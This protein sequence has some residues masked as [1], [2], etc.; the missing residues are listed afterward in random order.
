[1][2]VSHN[3][4]SF[5]F[6]SMEQQ[7]SVNIAQGIRF[8]VCLEADKAVSKV[9]GTKK[10]LLLFCF[11]FC[12]FCEHQPVTAVC[13]RD[14]EPDISKGT[15][16]NIVSSCITAGIHMRLSLICQ[17]CILLKLDP[18]VWADLLTCT[19]LGSSSLF[20]R[21]GEATAAM[22]VAKSTKG[23][24]KSQC[25]VC[26]FCSTVETCRAHDRLCGRGPTP[27]VSRKGLLYLKHNNSY[28]LVIRYTNRILMNVKFSF[29]HI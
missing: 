13:H 20:K 5:A 26:P 15:H 23:P 2:K 27:S 22:T 21:E 28:M 29:Y 19:H 18:S 16:S 8:N 4:F 25:W 24:L 6:T 3:H 1:M 10:M 9:W 11:C 12:F 7:D 17:M 14:Q